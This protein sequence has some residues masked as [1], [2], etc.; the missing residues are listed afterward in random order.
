MKTRALLAIT[1]L[2]GTASAQP[3]HHHKRETVAQAPGADD[4][5]EDPN[6]EPSDGP[7]AKAMLPVKLDDLIEVAVRLA[8]DLARAKVDRSVAIDTAAASR[9]DQA[10]VMTSHAEYSRSAVADHVEVPPFSVVATDQVSGGVGL[11]KNLPT[12]GSLSVEADLAHTNTEYNVYDRL[13]TGQGSAAQ[14]SPT[15][16]NS[17]NNPYEFLSQN[18]TKLAA[19]FKQP[20]ARGFGP[21]VALATQKKADLAATEATVKAQL[22]AEE[23]IRDIVDAYWEL[24]FAAYEVDIRTQAIELAQKQDQLT[25]EQIRAG[26][27]PSTALGQTTYE[28]ATRKEALLRAQIELEQKS[29][30]LRRKVGLEIGKRDIVV[31]PGEAFEVGNEDFD[32]DEILAR[33]HQANHQLA[34]V[35]IE[36]KIADVDLGVA[37]DQVKPTLDLQLQGAL[38]GNGDS[39]GESLGAVGDSFQVTAG[40]SMSFE[41]SGAARHARDAAAAKKHRLDI[42]RADLER[43]IDVQVVTAVKQVTAARTR[44]AL[45]DTAINVAEDNVRIEKTNFVAGKTSNFQV[46]QQQTQLIDARIQRG[47][48]IADYHEAVAQLQFLSGILLEQYRVNVRPHAEEH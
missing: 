1:L 18:Q 7:E 16:T 41:L 20:L 28:I 3:R 44:V 6:E 36:K 37:Q 4:T 34:S 22:A 8:P 24:A 21:D 39:T 13:F 45:A 11:A 9:R 31:K 47:R 42:D 17:N 12:G 29:L 35:Q 2:A 30:E 27:A 46:M 23:M 5:Q 32:V 10:W 40:V 25:H 26:A 38:M 43:Q 15:G 19:T 14:G 48:A 33:S